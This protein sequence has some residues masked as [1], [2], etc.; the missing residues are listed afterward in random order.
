MANRYTEKRLLENTSDQWNQW[1]E[2][3]YERSEKKRNPEKYETNLRN[4]SSIEWSDKKFEGY[5]LDLLS[6]RKSSFNRVTFRDCDL[7]STIFTNSTFHNSVFLD[8]G[9]LGTDFSYSRFDNCYFICTK[10]YGCIFCNTLLEKH[11]FEDTLIDRCNFHHTQIDR[12]FLK[13]TMIVGCDLS[14]ISG[15][16]TLDEESIAELDLSTLIRSKG[17]VHDNLLGACGVKVNQR[18]PLR[19]LFSE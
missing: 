6:F 14:T 8:C 13:Y 16:F 7:G 12:L 3:I 9:L 4:L 1:Y 2:N 10:L 18:K 5:S 15:L 11:S 17:K 19:D